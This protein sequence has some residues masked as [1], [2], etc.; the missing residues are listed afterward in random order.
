MK[1]KDVK[2]EVLPTV[3]TYSSNEYKYKLNLYI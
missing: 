3:G 2:V 1:S